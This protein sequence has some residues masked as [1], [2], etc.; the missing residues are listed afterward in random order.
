MQEDAEVV[1]LHE[2]EEKF[3]CIGT[4]NEE[5]LQSTGKLALLQ[6]A[7]RLI[8]GGASQVGIERSSSWTRNATK[9]PRSVKS[10]PSSVRSQ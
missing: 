10:W 7:V 9:I 1:L 5:G 3:Y 8:I 2:L 4:E 6:G